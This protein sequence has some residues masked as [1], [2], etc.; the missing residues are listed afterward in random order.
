[1]GFKDRLV[2][3]GLENMVFYELKRRSL[4]SRL[5]IPITG[6]R[7]LLRE[8]GGETICAGILSIEKQGNVIG[9]FYITGYKGSNF[10]DV[11]SM[12]DFWKENVERVQHVH[13]SD[14]LLWYFNFVA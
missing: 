10:H 4:R 6:N 8:T 9:I 12:D 1:M 2:S 14:Y 5:A 3:G 13:I 7:N 11:V